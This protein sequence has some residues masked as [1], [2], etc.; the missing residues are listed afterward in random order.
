MK[1]YVQPGERI[2]VTAAAAASAGDGVLIGNLFGVA[3][4][5]A[6]IGDSLTLATTGVYTMPKVST[7]A[8]TVGAVAFWDDSNGVVTTDDDTGSNARI[9]LAVTAAGNP[10][11]SVNVRLD[12]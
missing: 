8:F 6:E 2:T 4:G 7:D 3:F 5:D 1:T 11:A 10:S 12:G 9:G